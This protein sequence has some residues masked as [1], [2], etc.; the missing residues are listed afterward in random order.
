MRSGCCRALPR[1]RPSWREGGGGAV[2]LFVPSLSLSLS[3][4]SLDAFG[5]GLDERDLLLSVW[6]RASVKTKKNGST[7]LDAAAPPPSEA[8]APTARRPTLQYPAAAAA[9]PISRNETQTNSSN[10]IPRV[11][12]NK[13]RTMAG[14]VAAPIVVAV[15][16]ATLAYLIFKKKKGRGRGG[17]GATA[18][19]TKEE[20]EAPATSSSPADYGDLDSLV[21]FSSRVIAA[22]RAVES[23][24][25]DA[26]VHDPLAEH[27]AG[28]KALQVARARVAAAEQEAASSGAADAD[29][30]TTP[31][32]TTPSPPPR[33]VPRLVMR[34]A[35]LDDA[36]VL[37]ALGG[38]IPPGAA[39][40][41][42]LTT[43]AA[44]RALEP[45]AAYAREA[46]A[47][48]AAADDDSASPVR[49]LQVVLLGAGMDARPW[50][51]ALPP[52][53]VRWIEVDRADVI[54]AKQMAL[55]AAGA[56]VPGAAAAAAVSGGGGGGKKKAAPA[57][58]PP[59]PP[60]AMA[61]APSSALASRPSIVSVRSLQRSK[62]AA[63]AAAA[64]AA[65]ADDNK[66]AAAAALVPPPPFP[67]L[68]MCASSWTAVAADLTK[69][70]WAATLARE[71]R[72]DPTIPTLWVAEGLLYYLDPATVPAML[73]EAASVSC[74]G[75]A[76]VATVITDATLA[77]MKGGGGGG[78]GA[79]GGGEGANGSKKKQ[80]SSTAAAAAAEAAP[81]PPAAAASASAAAAQ[82]DAAALNSQGPGLTS[83]F[84]WGAPAEDVDGYFLQG[85]WRVLQRPTWSRAAEAYGWPAERR[86]G[87]RVPA[88]AQVQFLVAAVEREGAAGA[89]AK[90]KTDK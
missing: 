67:K 31:T 15:P 90:A 34:T 29:D 8:P 11:P 75:S 68:P 58:V 3:L 62:S 64:L 17:G 50:R 77:A 7:K 37:A 33:A 57:M 52:G 63:A 60:A 73:R 85:G 89:A 32:P 65:V 70:G 46:A 86:A 43:P 5:G 23:A 54:R 44:A 26:F 2:G 9:P 71:A 35:F 13:Q 80:G 74:R 69:P 40:R 88:E 28:A 84:V 25:P 79:H 24:R 36:V 51:L 38:V 4:S 18:A 76:L 22:A 66:E 14:A 30:N 81:S 16:V 6:C 49:T 87:S 21:S 1:K 47:A 39:G 45:L 78:G 56:E 10:S 41:R 20:E 12:P 48:A 61:A 27:L 42:L 53:R 59:P 83:Q 72:L 82:L 55:L 19:D